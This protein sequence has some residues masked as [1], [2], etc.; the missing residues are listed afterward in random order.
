MKAEERSLGRGRA[1]AVVTVGRYSDAEPAG[2]GGLAAKPVLETE[3][4]GL[5]LS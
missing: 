5:E 1:E 4:R 3:A 2:S